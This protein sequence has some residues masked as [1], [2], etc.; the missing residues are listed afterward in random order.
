[1]NLQEARKLAEAGK[2]VCYS[3]AGGWQR[4]LRFIWN[5]DLQSVTALAYNKQVAIFTSEGCRIDAWGYEHRISTREAINFCLSR[6]GF[7]HSS[8]N[9][10]YA[11]GEKYQPGMVIPYPGLPC[12]RYI[13]DSGIAGYGPDAGNDSFTVCTDWESVADATR[14]ELNR[15]AEF[16]YEGAE[17]EAD[18]GDYKAAWLAFKSSQDMGNLADCLNNERR[19]APLYLGNPKLWHETIRQIVTDRFPYDYAG[20]GRLYVWPDAEYGADSESESE[21]SL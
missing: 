4:W 3:N 7:L 11:G 10:I 21:D 9:V 6:P 17:C 20:G 16:V 15:L 18:S 5:A 1:M 19:N 14:D 13:V 2:P 8:K 12:P